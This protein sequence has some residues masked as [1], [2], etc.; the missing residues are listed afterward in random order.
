MVSKKSSPLNSSPAS[1]ISIPTM[2]GEE[3]VQELDP[4]YPKI[5]TPLRHGSTFQLLIAVVLS[6]QTT[7]VSVNKV[8][9]ALFARYP[10]PA[11]LAGASVRSL[12]K[13]VRSTGYFHVKAR[14]IK[15]ISRIIE[16][17]YSGKV[18]DT[19][20]GLL[21]LPGVG[22][23]T[24][25]IV[26]SAGFGKSEGIAVDTHVFRLSRR[27]GLTEKNTPEKIEQD[28]MTITPEKDWSRLTILLILHGRNV[29]FARNPECERCVLSSKCRYFAV[30][31]RE[32][33]KDEPGEKSASRAASPDTFFLP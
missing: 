13:L 24:A 9:P 3:V 5:K 14:R 32:N 30:D 20:E 8:V 12:E 15:E 7:D 17:D 18:P 10:T 31:Y 6:A 26:L 16:R 21:K 4:L 11:S 28:L 29:C 1:A 25:N 27:I 33:K 19:M 2:S 23:K 22:R